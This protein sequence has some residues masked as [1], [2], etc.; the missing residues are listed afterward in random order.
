ML[1]IEFNFLLSYYYSKWK[2]S[3]FRSYI[4]TYIRLPQTQH[5]LIFLISSTFNN[6]KSVNLIQVVILN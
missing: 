2:K 4:F 1:L 6:K 3:I 5:L